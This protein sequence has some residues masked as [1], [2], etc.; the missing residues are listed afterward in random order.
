MAS[1]LSL[2]STPWDGIPPQGVNPLLLGFYNTPET[3]T[4]VK[5]EIEGSIPT[6]VQGS[7]YRGA[8][9][10]WDAGNYTSSHWFDGFSRNHRFEIQNGQVEYRSRNASDEL[11]DF[12]RETGLLPGGSFGGDPCKTI[13]GE[14]ETKWRD[15]NNTVGDKNTAS[16]LVSYIKNFPGLARNSTNFGPFVTLVA[17]TDANELQQFD[18]VTLEP[19]ELFTYQSTNSALSSRF[20]SAHPSI[21]AKGEVYNYVLDLEGEV[22][23]YQVFG[24]FEGGEGRILANI[25]DAPPAYLHSVFGTENYIILI[26][27]QA[28]FGNNGEAT[29]ILDNMKPWDPSRPALFYVISKEEGGVVAKYTAPPFFAFHEINSFEQNGD[30]VIDLPKFSDN[31]WL[32]GARIPNLRANVGKPNASSLDLQGEFVRFRLPDFEAGKF[33]NGT[34]V[35]RPAVEEL[36]FPPT[37][38]NLELPKINEAYL[39]KPYRYAYG[40]HTVQRG[41][42]A[43]SIVKIDVE[44]QT[45][46]VWKPDTNHLPSEPIFVAKPNATCEDDGALVFIAMDERRSASSLI[47]LDARTMEEFGRA[48]VPVAVGY[49]FH[50]IWGGA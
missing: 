15:G 25:T 27:W 24:V 1:F 30:I 23:T 22:P 41:F 11:N 6:W 39:H 37:I 16:V 48:K 38:G 43:D 19:I 14:F 3:L 18:P 35:T 32:F 42:F 20:S 12:V 45:S 50:G 31:S 44:T 9:A 40:I 34:I 26:V 29:N 21:G 49:G 36:H 17:T 2:A 10:G 47:V 28:D 46:K 7:L 4:P 33:S 13:F 8:H 5:L